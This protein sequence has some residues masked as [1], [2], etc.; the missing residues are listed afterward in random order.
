VIQSYA[1]AILDVTWSADSTQIVS[2]GSKTPLTLW[3]VMG[4]R[5]P[6]VL[7]DPS[8]LICSV[9]WSPDGRYLATSERDHAIELW[10]AET[11]TRI[12]TLQPPDQNG[13][14]LYNLAWSPD[15]Q[16]LAWGT[17]ADAIVVFDR[18]ARRYQR[19]GSRF[20]TRL[21]HVAWSP[22]GRYLVGCGYSS[23][24]YI[25]DAHD[26]RLLREF[27]E[28]AGMIMALDWNADSVRLAVSGSTMTGGQVTVW[29]VERGKRLSQMN[30]LDYAV[31]ATVWD[32]DDETLII[33]DSEGMLRW[34]DMTTH[35]FL[36]TQ[37]GHAG[38]IQALRKN[39]EQRLLASCGNDGAIVIWDMERREPLRTLRHDRPYERLD[40]TGL[41]GFT[42]DQKAILR[43]LGAI[44]RP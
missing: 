16:R 30:S 5:S 9:G 36:Q 14:V 31:S 43:S 25:W 1:A 34:W 3:D 12:E 19:T 26:F 27:A 20:P 18:T 8:R 10:D 33:G 39:K 32:S 35:D 37:R 17:Y 7:Q 6:Q 40:I 11:W 23:V 2:G 22:D 44:E 13:Q 4:M 15:G 28:D 24:I 42:D 21:R 38:M 29:D 41:Q